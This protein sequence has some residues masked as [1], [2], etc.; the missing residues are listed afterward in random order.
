MICQYSVDK[1]K[2]T[3]QQL[4]ENNRCA[5]YILP[6]KP[7]KFRVRIHKCFQNFL[8]IK[9]KNVCFFSVCLNVL[10]EYITN[11]YNLQLNIFLRYNIME[12]DAQGAAA[13]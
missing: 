1:S 5:K 13:P 11:Y 4:L 6:V 3:V 9:K 2:Y 7:S 12:L 10:F 8:G